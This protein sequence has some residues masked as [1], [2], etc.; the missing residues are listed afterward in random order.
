MMIDQRNGYQMSD[1][2]RWKRE[3]KD[4]IGGNEENNKE[5]M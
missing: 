5:R 4:D 3:P 1:E 2:K